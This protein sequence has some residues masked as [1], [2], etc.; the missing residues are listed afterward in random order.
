MKSFRF[1]RSVLAL[2]CILTLLLPAA[3]AEGTDPSVLDQ[4]AAEIFR[5]FHTVGGMVTVAKDGKII[6]QYCYGYADKGRKLMA[7]EDCYYRLAS[8]SKLVTACAAMRLVDE[9]RLDLDANLG[10]IIGGDDPYFACNPAY[11]ETGITPRMLMS[12][13]SAIWDSH[14][15]TSRP[16]RDALKQRSSFYKG[17]CPGTEYHYS[18]YAAG[19]MGIVLE[20]VTGLHLSAAVSS[21][22][23]EPMGISGAYSP[24][25]LDHPDLATSEFARPY[26]EEIDLENDYYLS[27]GGC[28]MK[29][30][31][32]C[33]IGMM[34]CDYGMLDGK[35][36]LQENTVREM[37]SSQQG[38]GGITANSPYGLNVH[39]LTTLVPDRIIYG[40]QGRIEDTLCN[41]Y[42]DPQSRFVFSMVTGSCSP[43]DTAYGVRPPAYSLLKL[44]WSEFVG[45]WQH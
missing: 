23:F 18:N 29:G 28:W 1:L 30:Q 31:D 35:R 17:D 6:Y 25:L 32:L 14:F 27:Y 45:P 15:A 26:S 8:V 7:T 4:K 12:H 36:I 10:S 33:R 16:L 41:L 5:R 44:L 24:A 22:L 2:I 20:A 3:A 42:F 39:R 34:L 40:H 13:T 9:G 21:L 19:M 37:L 11:P 43:G 38:K